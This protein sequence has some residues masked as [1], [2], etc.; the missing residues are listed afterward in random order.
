MMIDN[1]LFSVLV[2]NYNNGR[3]LRDA[4]DSV[5]QQTYPHW[6]VVIVDDGST[7]DSF[8]IY[9]ELE[10]D[11]RFKVIL[12]GTNRGCTFSKKRCVDE[13]VG[14][15]CGYL[16]ADDALLPNALDVMV[17]A[18]KKRE[19][20][21]VVISRH[22]DCDGMLNM[23]GKSRLL[24]LKNGES[25]LTHADFMPEHF[26][27]FKKSKYNLTQGLNP[28]NIIGDDQE[29]LLLLEEV[30]DFV[31]LD[32]FTYKYRQQ[33]DSMIHKRSDECVY[34]NARVF[35]EACLRRGLDPRLAVDYYLGYLNSIRGES[36]WLAEKEV[37]ERIHQTHAYRLGKL[38]LSPFSWIKR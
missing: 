8:K 37:T 4:I 25:Y 16:D 27:S 7:D 14:E 2:A 23:K 10:G 3:Y 1:P 32:E 22:Y 5:R 31:V 28:N 38:L 33:P 24:K 20:A 29:L 9:Q 30:G 19:K 26:V 34:W 12:N 6:Q 11:E 18:H 17:D 13:A 21:S 35:H 15:L 36:A